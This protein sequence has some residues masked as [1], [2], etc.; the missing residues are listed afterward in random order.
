[1]VSLLEH[2]RRLRQHEFSVIPIKNKR[3]VLEKWTDRRHQLATDEELV[4]WFSNGKADV[5]SLF[6][7]K[8]MHRFSQILK[9]KIDKTMHTR[10][11]HGHHRSFKI[12]EAVGPR[13]SQPEPDAA[14]QTT[15][16]EHY[17]SNESKVRS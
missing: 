11:S 13:N 4:S 1:M 12:S 15:S 8:I 2:A 16:K 17:Y 9:D 10:T 7:N 5:K 3:P 14:H 6:Q